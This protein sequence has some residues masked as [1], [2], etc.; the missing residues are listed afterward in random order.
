MSGRPRCANCR[1]AFTP[2]YRNRTKVEN[3]QR[4]CPECGPVVGHRL[5]D[6]RYRTDNAA[7]RSKS[8]RVA[9]LAPAAARTAPLPEP[10]R[11]DES[12]V[13]AARSGSAPEFAGQ[14][15]AHLAA[16]AA[17]VG[18]L[19]APDSCKPSWPLPIGILEKSSPTAA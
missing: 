18:D 5:A 6:R 12:L 19:G 2:N 17:L 16:I 14:I 9:T 15:G 7:P 1:R 8:V 11:S 4:V 3:R 13:A 10:S